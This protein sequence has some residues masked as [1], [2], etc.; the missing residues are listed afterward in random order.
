[1]CEVVGLIRHSRRKTSDDRKMGYESSAN[2]RASHENGV[3]CLPCKKVITGNANRRDL[4]NKRP[5]IRDPSVAISCSVYLN[6]NGSI[7]V[8]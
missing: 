6:R 5:G 2:Q 1:M 8:F 7:R 3:E 4:D